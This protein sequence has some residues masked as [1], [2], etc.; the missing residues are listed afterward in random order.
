MIKYHYAGGHLSQEEE[1]TLIFESLVYEFS[2]DFWLFTRGAI[3]EY[4]LK[5]WTP[6]KIRDKI[7]K[8]W[9]ALFTWYD[10]ISST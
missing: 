7:T 5:N 4:G 3:L 8:S 2:I 6:D 10:E 1:V 9:I